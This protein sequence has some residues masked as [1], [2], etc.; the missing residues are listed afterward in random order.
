MEFLNGCIETQFALIGW[1][2]ERLIEAKEL[3]VAASNVD[4]KQ[5]VL[6]HL[7]TNWFLLTERKKGFSSEKSKSR[8][9]IIKIK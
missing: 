2:V 3:H 1:R 6:L 8:R 9:W 5:R 4:H 7:E